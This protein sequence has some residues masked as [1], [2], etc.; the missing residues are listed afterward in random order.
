MV[1]HIWNLAGKTEVKSGI[2]HWYSHPKIRD[3]P[4]NNNHKFQESFF[5]AVGDFFKIYLIVK[6]RCPKCAFFS[7]FLSRISLMDF[8]SSFVSFFHFRFSITQ[9]KQKCHKRLL[10]G[11]IASEKAWLDAALLMM[12]LQENYKL[13]FSTY[14]PNFHFYDFQNLFEEIFFH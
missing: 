5:F 7:T 2:Y 11:V 9:W 14:Y 12:A 8:L 13:V 1:F 4:Q 3:W 10:L 6:S